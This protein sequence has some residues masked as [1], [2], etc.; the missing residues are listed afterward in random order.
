MRVFLQRT[1]SS[2]VWI[3]GN[4]HSQV[5]SG[6]TLLFGTKTGDTEASCRFLAEKVVN[7]RIF[8]DTEQ[9]MNLSALDVKAEI[10]IISQ[11]TL[12]ADWRKGRRPAFTDAME[13]VEAERLYQKFIAVVK[14]SGLRV[15]TGVFAA[16]MD[17]HLIN[18][19]PVSLLLEHDAS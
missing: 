6:L 17:I 4:R 13:P 12:Y 19:G 15:E 18:H 2:E 3:A 11:F 16:K 7:L 1:S 8:E 9:K 5:G 10:M 14:E